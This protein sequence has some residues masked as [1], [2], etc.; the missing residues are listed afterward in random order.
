MNQNLVEL[1][2]LQ[3]ANLLRAGIYRLFEKTDHINKIN[4]FPVPD[5]DTG[6]NMS[7]TLSAVLASLDRSPEPHA[8]SM[9]VRAADA[10]LDGARGNS[11]AILAQF[12][13]GL[14][15]GAGHLA[16]LTIG[17]FVLAL[18]KGAGYAKEALSQ[19]REGTILT[20]LREFAD[21]AE[22]QAARSPDFRSLFE[23]SLSRV[24]EALEATRNQLEELRAANVVDA[25]ALGFVEVLEGMR[26]FLETGELGTVVAPVH[27]GDE[28]MAG[29]AAPAVDQDYRYCTECL[30][31]AKSGEDIDLRLLRETLSSA[32]AS[33]VVSGS[34]RKAKIHVHVDDPES[35]FRIAETFG[36]LSGQKADDMRMQ[37]SAA[38]HRR[39]Q[40][41]AVIVDSGADVPEE[42]V[43]RYGIHVVPV[44]IH[45]ANYSYLD[46]V[47]MTPSEFYRELV[48]NPAHPKTSQPPPG[49]FRRMFEFLAS[50]YDAVVSINLTSRHSGTWDAATKAA[51]RVA[52]EGKPVAALDSRNASVGQGL[53]AIAAAEAA[54]QGVDAPA[55]VA[56]AQVAMNNTQTFALLGSIDFAVRGGRVPAI[57]GKVARLLGL[58]VILRT[59]PDGR[60]S[61]GGGL[62]GPLKLRSRFARFVARRY[63]IDP[64]KETVR[65]LVGHGDRQ[66]EGRLLADELVAKYPK[67]SVE[68]CALT[69]MGPAIGVHGGPGTLIVAL[70]RIPK[71]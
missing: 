56:A 19:P 30:L 5:G 39:T 48:T 49:D 20:V 69:D 53:I 71:A 42:F 61:A 63:R 3:L 60:I 11:G 31:T 67:G 23:H 15:D 52:S 58:N 7:L 2:G 10:A 41:V 6:T 36:E 27:S 44:R 55:V 26:R 65:I 50:H 43:D 59:W 24:N 32:G 21:A 46:K 12:L 33:L 28:I 45:F 62:F 29:S 35:I 66:E 64:A 9:L 70:H 1:D 13:L 40:R 25:G 68:F 14:G 17:E 18:R 37:Q 47:S 51:Q 22:A 34:K 54:S 16:R 8:G 4:V 57:V 38:H